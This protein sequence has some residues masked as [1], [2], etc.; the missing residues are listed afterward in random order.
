ML[1]FDLADAASVEELAAKTPCDYLS[2]PLEHAFDFDLGRG[3]C[4]PQW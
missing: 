3:I 4:F 1:V 2:L